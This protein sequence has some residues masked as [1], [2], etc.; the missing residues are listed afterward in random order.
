MTFVDKQ[1]RLPP[2][3]STHSIHPDCLASASLT[4]AETAAAAAPCGHARGN[5]GRHTCDNSTIGAMV[6][7]ARADMFRGC[8]PCSRPSS[9]YLLLCS[10]HE[11]LITRSPDHPVVRGQRMHHR[12]DG[13]SGMH[14]LSPTRAG[15]RARVRVLQSVARALPPL[16][17][18]SSPVHLIPRPPA[19][20]ITCSHPSQ[21]RVIG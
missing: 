14:L 21:D 4:A 17:P 10:S 15:L 16:L 1:H 3:H 6:A 19:H 2:Y 5:K 13:R 8:T 9:A 18:C 7:A 20:P 11:H 12:C